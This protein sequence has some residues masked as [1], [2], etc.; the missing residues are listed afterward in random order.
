MMMNQQ[1]DQVS[2]CSS[3]QDYSMLSAEQLLALL[4]IGLINEEDICC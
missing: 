1:E 4:Q 2:F 3:E